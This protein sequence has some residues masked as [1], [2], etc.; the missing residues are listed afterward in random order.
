MARWSERGVSWLVIATSALG[1]SWVQPQVMESFQAAKET[2][3]VYALPKPDQSVVMSLGHRSAFADYLYAT[4]RVSYGQHGKDKR[5]FEFIEQYLDTI[6]TLDPT[7]VEPYMFTDTFLTL[8]TGVEEKDHYAARR[9]L[10]RGMEALP[11]SQRLWNSA[12]QYLAYI[13]PQRVTDP[14][15]KEA[16]RLEGARV[17]AH[18]CS[19]AS[20]NANIP[21]HCLTAASL[22]SKAGERSALIDMMK[23]TLAVNDDPEIRRRA[24]TF[25][26]DKIGKEE[27]EKQDR[28][29]NAFK[30]QWKSET[31]FVSLDL[32]LVLGPGFDPAKC[33]GQVSQVS[34]GCAT[35][36]YAWHEQNQY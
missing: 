25:L 33:A 26:Q 8:Q 24:L 3:D 35:S 30:K 29:F 16:W 18:A 23:K 13:G 4:I 5:R 17:L 10:R 28:R 12:G 7:F 14:A 2:T 1:L 31:G 32:A 6:T 20:D 9:I 27:R 19:L 21:Y 15:E 11:H 22:L 36:W 34:P